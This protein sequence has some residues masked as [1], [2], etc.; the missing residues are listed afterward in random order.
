MKINTC[1]KL[2]ESTDNM[3]L[4]IAGLSPL[5]VLAKVLKCLWQLQR[6]NGHPVDHVLLDG[7]PTQRLQR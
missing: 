2:G 6:V 1:W 3:F 4:S 7:L 5:F